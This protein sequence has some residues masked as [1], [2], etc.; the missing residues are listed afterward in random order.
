MTRRIDRPEQ[1][2]QASLVK[3]LR[4]VLTPQTTFF[5]V[6]NGGFRSKVEAAIMVGQG[7]MPGVP[8]IVVVHDGRAFGLELKSPKGTLSTSQHAAHAILSYAGMK[9]EIARS[10]D[11]ALMHLA[12]WG[13]PTRIK[14]EGRRSRPDSGGARIGGR[15]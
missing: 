2:F 9:I 14:V 13:I 4:S 10:T 5:A 12:R 8:D 1:Q 3:T 11:E 7:V 15:T 6:P